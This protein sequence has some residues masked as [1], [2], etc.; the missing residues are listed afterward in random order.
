[1]RPPSLQLRLLTAALILIN[2]G[3]P[4]LLIYEL[5]EGTQTQSLLAISPTLFVAPELDIAA[6]S[7]SPARALQDK[8]LLYTS[9]HFYTPPP[10]S[11]V[12]VTP[13]KPDYRLVGTFVIPAKPTVALLSSASGTSRKVKAGDKLDGWLVQ[14]VETRRVLLQFA[15]TTLEISN[16]SKVSPAGMRLVPLTRS[17]H[18]ASV[19][20]IRTL[21]SSAQGLSLSSAD[22]AT[23]SSSPRLYRPPPK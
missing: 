2:M 9:R 1:M 18:P 20:G 19:N 11:S 12:P 21:G 8:T 10:P 13:P 3:V 17:P 14:A 7:W 16:G 4:A 23:T 6:P 22:L 15:D 5:W